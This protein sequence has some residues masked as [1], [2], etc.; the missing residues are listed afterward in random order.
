M[1]FET[2]KTVSPDQTKN[3]KKTQIV[4]KLKWCKTQ[5]LPSNLVQSTQHTGEMDSGKPFAILNYF[6]STYFH[7][8]LS[9]RK[10]LTLLINF[11]VELIFR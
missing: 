3:S 10:T 5:I 9:K 2:Y 1:N 7:A 11:Q 6:R 4:T 8:S